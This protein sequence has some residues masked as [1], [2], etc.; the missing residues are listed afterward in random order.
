[1]T[2]PGSYGRKGFFSEGAKRKRIFFGGGSEP[3]A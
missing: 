1:M 3:E 2:M